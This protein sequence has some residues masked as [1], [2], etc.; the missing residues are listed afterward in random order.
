MRDVSLGLDIGSDSIKAVLLRRRGS[1]TQVLHA[2]SVPLEALGHLEDSPRKL[3]KEAMI[4]RH[5]L[6]RLGIRGVPARIGV[7]GRKSIIRYTRVPPAPAWRLK[8]LIAYE[9]EGDTENAGRDLAYDFRLL[10]LPTSE[11]EF[12][13]MMAMAK[14]ELVED[15]CAILREAGC[16]IDN[17]TLS[18]LALFN[19]GLHN[20]GGRQEDDKTTLLVDIGSENMNLVVQRNGRLLFARNISPAGRAFTQAV[21]DELRLS[22]EEAERLKC[23]QGRLLL[24][25]EARSTDD[26]QVSATPDAPTEIGPAAEA[27]APDHIAMGRMLLPDDGPALNTS[28]PDPTAALS[29]A[30]LPVAGRLASAIQSSLMYCRAQTRLTDLDIDEIMLTGGGS[31]LPGLRQAIGRRLGIPVVPADPLKGFDLTPLRREEREHL[32]SHAETFATALGLAVSRLE[33]EAVNF[34][35]LPRRIKERR[36]FLNRTLYLWLTGAAMLAAVAVLGYSSWRHTERLREHV[37]QKEA[38][39]AANQEALAQLERLLLVNQQVAS[40]IGLMQDYYRGPRRDLKAFGALR[41][42]IP[43][44]VELTG[45]KTQTQGTSVSLL[46]DGMV[47]SRVQLHGGQEERIDPAT[48]LQI[49]GSLRDRLRDDPTFEPPPDSRPIIRYTSLR[50]EGRSVAKFTLELRTTKDNDD[51]LVGRK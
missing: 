34:S 27:E 45:M 2:G 9:I 21:Q 17:V 24:G 49:I 7:A 4:I 6:R 31:R 19:T 30:M 18:P 5:L 37:Q 8:M 47:L 16:G 11:V 38:R 15:Q 22:F 29:E 41:R 33:P 28:E 48:A 12:T 25:G 1:R 20:R 40:E 39:L 46:I 50:D 35:L 43:P 51:T 42:H 26:T 10:D 32:E 36:R 14:N 23:E 13:V 3:T 44:E